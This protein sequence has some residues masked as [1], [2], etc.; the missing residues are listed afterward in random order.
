MNNI[1]RR[2]SRD[3]KRIMKEDSFGRITYKQA[4]KRFKLFQQ[5]V[6]Y[7]AKKG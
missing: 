5:F 2:V 4:K 3:I 7:I 6:D 1:Q